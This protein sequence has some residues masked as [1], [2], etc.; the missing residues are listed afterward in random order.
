MGAALLFFIVIGALT[1]WVEYRLEL[2]DTPRLTDVGFLTCNEFKYI[3]VGFA[4][5]MT[6][7]KFVLLTEKTGNF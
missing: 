3:G 1:R 2:R 6:F 7:L 5:L 4:G